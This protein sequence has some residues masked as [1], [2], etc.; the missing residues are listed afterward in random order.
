VTE[1]GNSNWADLDFVAI[2]TQPEV[3][4]IGLDFRGDSL[5]LE[6]HVE[7]PRFQPDGFVEPINFPTLE[8]ITNFGLLQKEI[9]LQFNENFLDDVW[10]AHVA[11]HYRAGDDFPD[12]GADT[13][14]FNVEVSAPSGFLEVL[15]RADLTYTL[16]PRMT[17]SGPTSVSPQNFVELDVSVENGRLPLTYEW[18]HNDELVKMD[19]V[20]SYFNGYTTFG[21]ETGTHRFDVIVT[22]ADGDAN[23]KSHW[24]ESCMDCGS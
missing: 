15:G 6:G 1:A 12:Q 9:D 8:V 19:V 22:D 5:P 11:N 3:C 16:T 4:P 21:L 2:V 13:L 7:F 24:V 23:N 20:N 17:I 10:R 18:Y 14:V